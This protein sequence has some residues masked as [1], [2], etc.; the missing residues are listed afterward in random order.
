MFQKPAETPDEIEQSKPL[1]IPPE[2]IAKMDEAEWYAKAYRGDAPQL[3]VRAVL[4]GSVLGFFL[5]FTNIYVGLKAGW[6]LGVGITACILSFAT[7]SA[8]LRARIAKTPM[9]ILEN[10]CMQS[11]ASAAGFSTGMVL[12]SAV[13][14][15]LLLTGRQLSWRVVVPWIFFTAV[16]GVVMAI[17]MKRT[18]INREKLKFPT[19]TAAAVTLQSLYG[20][21]REAIVKAR[22]LMIAALFA[23]SIPLLKDLNAVRRCGADGRLAL[24]PVF[25]DDLNVFDGRLH[26]IARYFDAKLGVFKEKAYELSQ[27]HIKLDHS[28]VLIAAGA[29]I[30]VRVTASML[31]GALV[32]VLDVGPRALE[33]GWTNPAGTLVTAATSPANAFAKIGIWY[34]APMMVAYGLMTFAIGWRTIARAFSGFGGKPP[35]D[36][37]PRVSQVEVPTSWFAVGMAVAGTGLVL[38]AWKNFD[39]PPHLGALS[40]LVT[41][42]LA[43]VACRA[44]GETDVTP[45]GPM[46]KIMQ[47]TYGALMPQN[48]QANLMTAAITSGGAIASADLLTD[49]KSG[50][51]LGANPRR[52]FVAQFLGIFTGTVAS[53]TAYYFLVPSIEAIRAPEGAAHAAKFAAPAAQQWEAVARVFAEGFANLHPM[54]R[55]GIMVGIAWGI[56]LAIAEVIFP[57]LRTWIPSA[58]GLG[59]GLMFPFATSLSFFIGAVLAVIFQRVS[60]RQAERF[61]VPISSGLIA[62]ESVVGVVVQGLNNFV[63][64]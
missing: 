37:D 19:G 15:L 36:E 48:V 62:G 61:V 14:A 46:G 44:T 38:I 43:L 16:L 5:C 2:E 17:P 18:M 11:V 53:C 50:Y 29:I 4:M 6:A 58:T 47:L 21:G 13:P 57:K 45:G 27:W 56:A 8:L 1:D 42:L 39:I 7:W 22:A 41:F 55:H 63:L 35:A 10:N 33:W 34:G 32:L 40:V 12:V 25:P 24:E 23:L 3:T 30:G 9:S 52:Q 26:I 28:V 31:V 49:L 20:N 64:K 54:A 51:L 60:E 59:L